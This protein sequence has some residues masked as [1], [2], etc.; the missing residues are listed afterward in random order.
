MKHK[1]I[2][3]ILVLFAMLLSIFPEKVEAQGTTNPP[4]DFFQLPWEQGLSWVAYDGFDNGTRRP[5]T[6]PHY[7]QLGGAVDFAPHAGMVVGEDTS[8]F[9]VTAAADG[10]VTTVSSCHIV[11][12]HGNG[13]T[14]EYW[15]LANIQVQNSQVVT[16]NQ[17]IAIIADN[18]LFQVC[19]GNRHPGPHLHFV[20][21]PNMAVT[22]FA[23][24]TINFNVNTNQTTF[25]KN[26]QTVGLLQPL[27]NSM[28]VSGTATP[29][30]TITRTNT[31]TPTRTTTPTLTSTPTTTPTQ[32][33]TPPPTNTVTATTTMTPVVT[34]TST[35]T[36]TPVVS[37]TP[38]VS[39]TPVFTNT[40]TPTGTQVI[41]NTPTITNTPIVNTPTS[42]QTAVMTNTPTSTL[43]VTNTPTA[44]SPVTNTNTPTSTSVITNTPVFTN[45]PTLTNTATV[46][47]P[48][49]TATSTA[50]SL[51][52]GPYILTDAA[53][54]NLLV[55]QGSL[56]TVSL[57][58]VPP[59]GYVSAEITCTYNAS[60]LSVSNIAV[61]GLFGPNPVVAINGPQNGSFILAMVATGGNK[62]TTSGTV[63]TFS[64]TALQVGQS[65]VSCTANVSQGQSI[66]QS[67]AF[68]GD[69]V[70]ILSG[71]PTPTVTAT[72]VSAPTQLT[73]Q[74][75]AS[76]PV[77]IRLYNLDSSL[78]ATIPA[79]PDG[80]F[81]L[82]FGPGSYT[83]V[84]SAEGF[85]NAQGSVTLVSG[86]TTTKPTI[87]LIPGDVDGNSIINQLDALTIGMN[88][89]AVT[90]TAADLNNDGV[91][92]VLDLQLLA[93][94]YGQS[95]A[96][97]W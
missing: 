85:L 44:T 16:R 2:L 49:S 75:I 25:T 89:N 83:V 86:T 23:G 17:R 55:G 13:W 38:T 61:A 50:T 80:T 92:N 28:P 73:G 5:R 79:N 71:T 93:A 34:N 97:A 82:N 65:P 91:I 78:A 8:N 30:R 35:V 29:T 24:W 11:I 3:Q 87:N 81:S 90:P 52:T 46:N 54:P 60:L 37:N 72:T 62:A 1:N 26:G 56:V 31:V 88:Y 57:N 45:T 32:T 33:N 51:P 68:V 36:G 21:R 76:K 59:A 48:T 96:L 69:T 47:T 9:W 70:N 58:N 12:D 43:A 4:A 39:N 64:V 95:G 63:L 10:I 18:V 67:I 41:T 7:Y 40:S 94:N 77:T 20:M 6:S 42:T 15:H 66:Y 27:L 19:T 22:Q 74:V 84:A 14:T 53:Q